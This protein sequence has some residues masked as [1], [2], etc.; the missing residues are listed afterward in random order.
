[1]KAG[2]VIFYHP[3]KEMRM[4]TLAL[5]EARRNGRTKPNAQDNRT[6]YEALMKESFDDAMDQAESE[7][8]TGRDQKIRA[9]EILEESRPEMAI[10]EAEAYAAR[11]TYNE[12]PI[13]TLGTLA[14][15]INSARRRI[16]GFNYIMPF[17]NTIMNVA[18]S[19]MNYNPV[20]GVT[21]L[22]KNS[23]GW[24]SKS[25]TYRALT[26]EDRAKIAIKS[27]I[28][29]LAMVALY[30]MDD[31][32]DKDSE[33][34][35]TAN[36]YGDFRKNY[37]LERTGW[38]AYSV[39]IG[40][41]WFSYKNTPLALV[42]API[43]FMKDAQRYRKSPNI[44]EEISILAGGSIKFFMDMSTLSG[45]AD[46]FD[47]FSKSN[48][49]EQASSIDKGRKYFEKIGKSVIVP[50]YFTQISR[51]IQEFTDTPIK[52]A[53][54]ISESI[55][56]DMPVLRD[57]LGN[58]YDAF[59][60]PV[61]PKQLEKLIPLNLSRTPKDVDLFNFLKEHKL[62]VGV[63]A[64]SNLKPNGEM[65]TEDEYN[66]FALQSARQIK[67]R[68]LREYKIYERMDN[69]NEIDDWFSRLKSE[70]RRDA[71]MNLFGYF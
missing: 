43:G 7:G 22:I 11:E 47:I 12:K 63:P 55:I 16:K 45:L 54:N 1:M 8:F 70:E 2:D 68:L 38:R 36:G 40:E 15:I 30:S 58:L 18:N 57:R 67:A 20:F 66:K 32:D 44:K 25:Q 69:K 46:F 4:A 34:E 27:T 39:R 26:A 14:E 60:D 3:F 48:I 29:T 13:G 21:R 37:E 42:M 28:G 65:M 35:I 19:Y 9:Y 6:I 31:P 71:K 49:S 41:N 5:Q 10:E 62:L 33:F 52:R 24:D 53:N 23:Y 50:N 61:T 17:V 64:K 51:L 59:G 56:R